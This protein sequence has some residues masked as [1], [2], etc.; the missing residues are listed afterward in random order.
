MANK[1]HDLSSEEIKEIF[2]PFYR[3]SRIKN[4]TSGFGLG[5]T[6]AQKVVEGHGGHLIALINNHYVEFSIEIPIDKK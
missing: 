3:S 1:G 6:I 4:N 2:K 5:L